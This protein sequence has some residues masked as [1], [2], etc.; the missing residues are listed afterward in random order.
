MFTLRLA[1]SDDTPNLRELIQRSVRGLSAGYY[2]E[3]EIESA[4]IHIFGPDTALIDDGT[5]A[6]IEAGSVLAA[7]GGWS[8][9]STLCGGDQLKSGS[10]SRLDPARD[11]A[12]IR[13]FFVHPDFAR[14]GL[15]RMLYTWC[16]GQARDAGFRRFELIATLPGEPLYSALG[17]EPVERYALPMSNGVD[18]PV[19]RMVRAIE[20][21]KEEA[22]A[23]T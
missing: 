12:R 2:S 10:E 21:A 23:S 19:V 15:G 17:F 13:A 18:L 22:R 7:A 3:Q 6:V 8:R 5:Y 4:L 1:I 20:G 14:R 16:E 11:A 9:L